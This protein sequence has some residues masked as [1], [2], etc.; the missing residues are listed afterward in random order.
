MRKTFL[1]VSLF[2]LLTVGMATSFTACKDYDDDIDNLQTQIDAMQKDLAEIKD[3]VSKGAVIT[4][5]TQ[6]ENGVTITL[7]NGN[8]Y[9]ITNGKDGQNGKDA[10]VWTIVKNAEGAYVWAKNGEATEFPAQGPAGEA[11]V[12][13]NYFKPNAETGKFDEYKADGTLVGATDIEW[14]ATVEQTLTAVDNGNTVTFYGLKDAEGNELEPQVLAKSGTLSGLEFIPDLYVNGIETMRAEDAQGQLSKAN[15]A[16]SAEQVTDIPVYNNGTAVTTGTGTIAKGEISSFTALT[17]DKNKYVY[18]KVN[19]ASYILNPNNANLDGVKFSFLTNDATLESR[20]SKASVQ[21]TSATKNEDGNLDVTYTIDDISNVKVG[22]ENTDKNVQTVM[23]LQGTLTDGSVISSNFV[24]LDGKTISF[25]NIEYNNGTWRIAPEVAKTAL[26]QTK[27]LM[28][29]VPYN[30]TTSLPELL[31]VSYGTNANYSLAELASK[32]GLTMSYSILNYTQ[33]TNAT[34]ENKYGAVNVSTGVFTPMY[35]NAS[36]ASVSAVGATGNTARSAIGRQPVVVLQLKDAE[37]NLVLGGFIKLILSEPETI[38]EPINLGS[39]TVPYI[40]DGVT[41]SAKWDVVAGQIIEATGMTVTQFQTN[42]K[43]QGGA[44]LVNGEYVAMT[45]GDEATDFGTFDWGTV[46]GNSQT[47]TLVLTM[48]ADQLKNFYSTFDK[49]GNF[50]GYALSTTPVTKTLYAKF[51]NEGTNNTLYIGYT[52]TVVGK[53]TVSYDGKLSTQW[54]AN[55][56][57]APVNPAVALQTGAVATNYSTLMTSIWVGGTPAFKAQAPFNFDNAKGDNYTPVSSVDYRFSATQ[58]EV[59]VGDV[60]YVIDYLKKKDGDK[61][62]VDNNTNAGGLGVDGYHILV[63]YDKKAGYESRQPIAVLKNG[64]IQY[65]NERGNGYGAAWMGYD[66][67]NANPYVKNN[68]SLRLNI[69]IYA[70]NG[71][72][73]YFV[74]PAFQMGFGAPVYVAEQPE[75]MQIT[76]AATEKVSIVNMCMLQDWQGNDLW[77]YQPAVAATETTSAKP[78]EVWIGKGIYQFWVKGDGNDVLKVLTDGTRETYKRGINIDLDGALVST[79]ANGIATAKPMNDIYANIK[80]SFDQAGTQKTL[81]IPAD[82]EGM[83]NAFNNN[84][85]Y[86]KNNGSSV[87]SKFYI[88]VPYTVTYTW[89]INVPMGYATIE[90]LPTAS[91]N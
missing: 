73:D 22:S 8:T 51:F 79:D 81:N 14:R 77:D 33:S 56:E 11:G 16:A 68:P 5:V 6:G 62:V 63:A 9:N 89:G 3:M 75:S 41:E 26:T 13:G 64:A 32:Y 65:L 38:N 36:G 20:A 78:A 84:F 55:G 39:F 37:G 61:Y 7:S 18:S 80:L 49:D 47:Q 86:Y 43:P 88:F 85:I 2:S 66:V 17:G 72:G 69:D 23:A 34:E 45:A 40:C 76:D 35:V 48:S 46:D 28:I 15:T 50:T 60:T 57:V 59:T 42:Y 70:N 1:K 74:A 24:A 71:C 25:A 21:V 4:S 10:D 12:A 27:D 58:P 31:R 30:A 67:L 29:A 83:K 90:I 19:S 52:V 91:A 82:S 54:T 53:P 44:V 87:I